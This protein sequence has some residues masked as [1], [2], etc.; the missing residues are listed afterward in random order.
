M[1]PGAGRRSAGSGR[2]R[3]RPPFPDHRVCLPAHESPP[4][5]LKSRLTT[6]R[7]P[8]DPGPAL[9]PERSG[10]LGVAPSP[11]RPSN[12]H[13]EPAR[14]RPAR[15]SALDRRGPLSHQGT[16]PGVD[17]WRDRTYAAAVLGLAVEADAGLVHDPS[18]PGHSGTRNAPAGVPDLLISPAVFHRNSPCLLGARQN[19]RGENQLRPNPRSHWLDH[20]P[21]PPGAG[22]AAPQLDIRQFPANWTTW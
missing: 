16:N 3:R 18:R 21:H 8:D 19:Q 13:A 2:L 22:A 5:C 4:V 1:S 7:C 6:R 12:P 11:G 10:P 14:P 15:S 17:R 9:Q 20:L